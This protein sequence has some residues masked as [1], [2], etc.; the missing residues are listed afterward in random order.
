MIPAG[1]PRT[2]PV[3]RRYH[4]LRVAYS[5]GLP[6]SRT[7]TGWHGQLDLVKVQFPISSES[8]L[9]MRPSWARY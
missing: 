5:A 1:W 9:F 4:A 2:A 3:T 6:R 8:V 7:H